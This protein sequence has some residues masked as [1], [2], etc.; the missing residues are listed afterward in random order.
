MNLNNISF[1]TSN[2]VVFFKGIYQSLHFGIIHQG[3]HILLGE[4]DFIARNSFFQIVLV[5]DKT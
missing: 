1:E 5:F 2:K 3:F 4:M